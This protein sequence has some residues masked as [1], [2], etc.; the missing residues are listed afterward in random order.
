[1]QV[2]DKDDVHRLSLHGLAGLNPHILERAQQA[3]ALG[4]IIQFIDC[5]DVAGHS[6]PRPGNGAVGDHWLEGV[7][8]QRH[9]AVKG[10][11]HIG[12][13]RSPIGNSPLPIL[14]LGRIGAPLDVFKGGLVRSNHTCAC[15]ALNTHIADC[16][17]IGHA[18][19]ANGAATVF[20]DVARAPGRAIL[21]NDGKDDVL[22]GDAQP[23][24]AFNVDGEV[25]RAS[26][27]AGTV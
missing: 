14:A 8:I 13:K 21:R 5:G 17:T 24:F 16:H 27:G 7:G 6:H 1:M 25:S 12:D 11:T 2:S 15:T 4:R 9:F 19:A 20:E 23:Q 10:S 18:Q 3:A 26:S 22:G